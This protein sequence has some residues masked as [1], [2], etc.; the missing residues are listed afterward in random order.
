[1]IQLSLLS[2]LS[3]AL[4]DDGDF[5]PSVEAGGMVFASWQ[6]NMTG[7]ADNYNEFGVDRAYATLKAKMAPKI[8]ARITLDADHFKAVTTPA[9]DLTLDTKYRLFLKHAYV[10]FKDVAPGVKVRA[11]MI[12]TPYQPNQDSFWGQRYLAKGLGDEEKLLSTADLG[13]SIGG[14]HGKGL[15]SWTAAVLNGEGYSKL[16]VDSGKALQARVTVDPIA[17]QGKMELPITAYVDYNVHAD[18][19]T[20]ITYAAALG[21]KQRFIWFSGEYLGV[22]EG[23]HGEMG[24]SVAALPGMPKYGRVVLRYDHFDPDTEVEA[25][26]HDRVYAG[27]SHDFADKVSLAFLYQ[28]TMPEA[29]GAAVEHG[30]GMHAQAGF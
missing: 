16:E 6:L 28:R 13:V 10:E 17:A 21:F 23:D 18:A 27:L 3:P 2:L 1:M 22:S 4:A 7:G 26:G 14:E 24:Y 20:R 9:G 8:G 25:D 19:D 5:K 15:F 29:D 11:G 12:D 30:V